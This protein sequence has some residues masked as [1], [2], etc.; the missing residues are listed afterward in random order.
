MNGA[1][2]N[3]NVDNS[4]FMALIILTG[5]GLLILSVKKPDNFFLRYSLITAFF[6]NII[7]FLSILWHKVRWGKRSQI[8]KNRQEE[9]IKKHAHK[10]SNTLKS[11]VAPKLVLNVFKKQSSLDRKLSDQEVEDVKK[12]V[13]DDPATFELI[14]GLTE[15]LGNEMEK[16]YNMIF[17][18]PLNERF[19]WLKYFAD[20]ITAKTRYYS[21]TIGIVFWFISLCLHL[22]S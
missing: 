16:E 6:F 20:I 8:F 11:F 7:C 12:S 2:E 19:A 18:K 21:F 22:F 4:I 14:L 9:I 1:T 5:S 10:I 17:R 3:N 13:A 15:N